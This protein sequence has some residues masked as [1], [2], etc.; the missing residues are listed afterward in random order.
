MTNFTAGSLKTRLH[1]TLPFSSLRE[2]F[3]KVHQDPVKMTT[4][5]SNEWA[6]AKAGSRSCYTY[7]VCTT[8]GYQFEV[9]SSG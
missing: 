1:G 6:V 4:C 3:P 8:C 7:Y 5:P 2:K 9:D